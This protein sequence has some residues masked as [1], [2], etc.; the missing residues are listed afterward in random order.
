M[1]F[2]FVLLFLFNA[3]IVTAKFVHPFI[4]SVNDGHHSHVRFGSSPVDPENDLYDD[5]GT[6]LLPHHHRRLG[7]LVHDT[8]RTRLIRLPNTWPQTNEGEIIEFELFDGV[9]VIAKTELLTVRGEDSVGWTGD[10][11][12]STGDYAED[13]KNSDGY[14]GLSCYKKSCV[15]QIKIYSTNQ[16]FNIA[17]SGIPL[18]EEGGG[19][20]AVSETYLDP[21]RKTGVKKEHMAH[22]HSSIPSFINNNNLRG[23]KISD[24]VAVVNDHIVDILVIYTPEAVTSQA[25]GR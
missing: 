15:A 21:S 7:S 5:D 2:K 25:G 1:I 19:I 10:V 22:N 14:F 6:H 24:L 3:I 12:I 20:Y 23:S 9:V 17:P 11:R 13:L 4:Q 18:D 16:E 8:L